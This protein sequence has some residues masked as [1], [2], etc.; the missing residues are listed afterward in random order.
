MKQIDEW[1]ILTPNGWTDF[2]GII[3][4]EKK[5]KTIIFQSGKEITASETHRLLLKSGDFIELNNLL[6]GDI[7]LSEDGSELVTTIS[8][9]K[10]TQKVYD[11][12]EVESENHRY[13]TNGLVS[14]NCDEMAFIPN[15]IQSEFMAG[16]APAL[17]ATRG[18]MI[19][20]ST[21]NGSRDL[22]A[23]LWFGSGMEWNKKEYTYMNNN[24]AR[25]DFVPLFVPYWIDDTKNNDKWISREKR[26]LDDPI[27]WK[28]EFE[29]LDEDT[30]VDIYDQ[31]TNEYK[32]IS[33]EDMNKQLEKDMVDSK[34]IIEEDI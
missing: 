18:K 30:M 21:P 10:N 26:T 24:Q 32:S 28:V 5:V 29:C 20:T 33:L 9:L 1:E 25:N 11:L 27:K 8:E 13:F 4:L 15:R 2:S 31:T 23:K 14:H 19:I 22:F 12:V 34:F 6:I 17:S 7:V 3:E 16:T